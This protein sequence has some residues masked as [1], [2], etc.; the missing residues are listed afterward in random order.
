M[1]PLKERANIYANSITEGGD[2][3]DRALFVAVLRD[4][5]I[6]GAKAVI[7]EIRKRVSRND[8]DYIERS[9]I[10][11]KDLETIL[12]ELEK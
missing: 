7:A 6:A 3:E 10:P 12:K 11:L 8:T 9:Y 1:T 4:T 2:P 5:Y